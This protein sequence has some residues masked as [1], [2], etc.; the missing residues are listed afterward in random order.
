MNVLSTI[1]HVKSVKFCWTENET[2]FRTYSFK[3]CLHE[4]STLPLAFD[5]KKA[6][7]NAHVTWASGKLRSQS[8]STLGRYGEKTF[9]NKNNFFQKLNTFWNSF[10]T[11]FKVL[12]YWALHSLFTCKLVIDCMNTVIQPPVPLTFYHKKATRIAHVTWASRKL[13]SQSKSTLGRY[14]EKP[15]FNKNNFF[16]KLNT[17]WNSF[18]TIFKVLQYWALHGL[19]KCKLV[20]DCKNTVIQPPVSLIIENSSY[21]LS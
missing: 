8:K 19:F 11:I 14:G 2:T 7:R 1:S 13:R 4:H 5:Y 17:F 6:T 18:L 3:K 12:Q 20:I 21:N 10:L 15:F 16:Q 9:F